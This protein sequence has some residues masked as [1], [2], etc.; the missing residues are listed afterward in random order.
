MALHETI[1]ESKTDNDNNAVRAGPN[2]DGTL[3][4][5]D[6]DNEEE[7]AKGKVQ[8]CAKQILLIPGNEKCCDCGSPD[9]KWASINL[10]I[11]LCIACSG[12]H[13]SLGVHISKVRSISLDVWEPEI[14]KVMAELGNNVVNKIYE[15]QVHE[16][17]AKRA[18]PESTAEE[19]ENWIK[20]KYIAKAFIKGHILES[21]KGM[22]NFKIHCS[23][24]SKIE[25]FDRQRQHWQVDS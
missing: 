2:S 24:N 8:R 5:E 17:V 22:F 23:F 15:A 16:V 14:L 20:A 25:Y 18:T 1:N 19:R 21:T 11:T 3:K 6:S 13:R 12:I 9:P 10:G 7:N 4:W